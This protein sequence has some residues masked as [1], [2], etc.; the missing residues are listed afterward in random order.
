MGILRSLF[1]GGSAAKGYIYERDEIVAR[2]DAEREFLGQAQGLTQGA[3]Y[4]EALR[5]VLQFMDRNPDRSRFCMFTTGT[6]MRACLGGGGMAALDP[7]VRGDPR[8]DAVFM[9]C[10]RGNALWVPNPEVK[11][12]HYASTS[13]RDP[14]QC[15]KCGNRGV[16]GRQPKLRPAEYAS[17]A[18]T[19]I[20]GVREHP[21][22]SWTLGQGMRATC[23]IVVTQELSDA[24]LATITLEHADIDSQTKVTPYRGEPRPDRAVLS[25]LAARWLLE[26]SAPFKQGLYATHG[27]AGAGRLE[28]VVMKGY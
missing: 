20:L 17:A 4:E 14:S 5:T 28:Y 25:T 10:P 19:E 22:G 7:C 21:A 12:P 15:P 27:L 2:T 3:K 26:T 24:S 11:G 23:A 1:G 9:A 8:L 18:G 16:A 13:G 6:V